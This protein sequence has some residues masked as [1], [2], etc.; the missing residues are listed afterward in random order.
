MKRFLIILV[1]IVLI[2]LISWGHIA[3]WHHWTW[4]HYIPGS[5]WIGT[6]I[7]AFVIGFIGAVATAGAVTGIKYTNAVIVALIC[8]G[9]QYLAFAPSFLTDGSWFDWVGLGLIMLIGAFVAGAFA[10]GNKDM[11]NALSNS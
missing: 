10:S 11:I 3:I 6:A 2:A 9:A 8:L 4:V 7:Y 5:A 1:A